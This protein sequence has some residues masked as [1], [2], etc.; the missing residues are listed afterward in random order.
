MKEGIDIAHYDIRYLKPIDEEMLHTLFKKFSKIV[1]VEDGTITG[2]L[3]SALLE[4]MSDNHYSAKVKRLGIP[5]DFIEHGKI[6]DLHKLCGYSPE[7]IFEE[8]IKM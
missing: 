6:S 8:I 5:D 7:K 2:G 1:T 4:F 3:G